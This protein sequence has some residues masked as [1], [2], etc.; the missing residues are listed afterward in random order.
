MPS[1]LLDMYGTELTDE[2]RAKL[3][4]AGIA[5]VESVFVPRASRQPGEHVWSQEG[6]LA[7]VVR[8]DAE[9]EEAAMS[10]C[11]EVLD[12]TRDLVRPHASAWG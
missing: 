6:P 10:H 7:F 2:C 8:V 4:A 11:A 9:S 5:I 3:E 1:F 12:L